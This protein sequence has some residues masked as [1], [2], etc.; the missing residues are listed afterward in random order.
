MISEVFKKPLGPE[1][2]EKEPVELYCPAV[3]TVSCAGS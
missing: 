3:V 1:Q 2:R